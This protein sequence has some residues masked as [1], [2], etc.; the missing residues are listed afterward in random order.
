MAEMG[1]NTGDNVIVIGG[2]N[3]GVPGT[4]VYTVYENRGTL[5]AGGCM[6]SDT[7][8]KK[9]AGNKSI[10]N[11]MQKLTPTLKRVLSR[12]FQL[13]YKAGLRNGEL[14]LTSEGKNEL[15]E[16][17]AVEKAKELTK[18]ASDIIADAKDN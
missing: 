17:L 1:F 2:C 15:L 14:A 11:M 9:V 13:Q 18:V 16:I 5:Y 7:K 8:W 4:K 3:G 12:D 6:C 10:N